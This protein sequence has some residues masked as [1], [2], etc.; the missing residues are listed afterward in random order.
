MGNL[1]DNGS[2]YFYLGQLFNYHWGENGKVSQE[3]FNGVPFAGKRTTASL[4]FFW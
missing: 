4:F 1:S 3:M 2:A